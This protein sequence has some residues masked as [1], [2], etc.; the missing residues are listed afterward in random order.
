MIASSFVSGYTRCARDLVTAEKCSTGHKY[1]PVPEIM[2]PN[3]TLF[4]SLMDRSMERP[5]GQKQKLWPFG[6]NLAQI[7][8]FAAPNL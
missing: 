6:P 4:Y 2:V 3:D 8:K 1:E 7:L 5:Q